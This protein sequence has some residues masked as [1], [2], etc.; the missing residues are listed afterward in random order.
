M[1]GKPKFNCPKCGGPLKRANAYYVK[2]GTIL[3][4]VYK[5]ENPDCNF[6]KRIDVSESRR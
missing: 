6:I 5:C 3:K 1:T 4:K 2:D